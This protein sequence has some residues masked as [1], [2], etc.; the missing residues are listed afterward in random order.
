MDNEKFIELKALIENASGK[1]INILRYDNC[2]EY[3]SN[4]FLHICSQS[5]IHIH[6][7]VPYTPQQN[8]VA[9]RKNRSLKEMTTCMLESK[10]L[11]ANLWVEAMHATSYIQ[12][13]VPHSFVK[14]KTPFE[15]Y[16]EHKLD[17]SNLRVFGSTAWAQIPLD[18]RRALQTQSIECLFIG[19]PNESKGFKLIYIKT[20]HIIIERS[21]CRAHVGR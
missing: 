16:F 19:N 7:S 20:K 12:N 1:K 13:R 14:G 3:V 2:R 5:G 15:A 6:H 8:S 4:D 21:V 17:V 10:K 9:E 11:A 18:K